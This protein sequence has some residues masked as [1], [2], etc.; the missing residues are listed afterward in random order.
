MDFRNKDKTVM[1]PSY[2]HN[3]NSYTGKIES[4]YWNDPLASWESY[5]VFVVDIFQEIDQYD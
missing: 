5:W 4:L 3:M 2:L 1:T